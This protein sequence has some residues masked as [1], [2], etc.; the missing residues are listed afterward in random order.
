MNLVLVLK[1]KNMLS[2][3]KKKSIIF[4]INTIYI[5]L[6]TLFESVYYQFY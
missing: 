1:Y 5:L 2:V 6:N 3:F 4:L